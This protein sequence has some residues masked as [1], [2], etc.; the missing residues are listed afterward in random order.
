MVQFRKSKKVGPFRFTL[1]PR[2]ISTSAGAGP[3]RVSRGADGKVRRTISAPGT[4]IYDTKVVGGKKRNAR[5]KSPTPTTSVAAARRYEHDGRSM[6]RAETVA[7]STL[8]ALTLPGYVFLGWL[9]WQL[10]SA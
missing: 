6:T 2:G 5:T 8:F 1:T 7:W 4:G 9:V 3:I 10:A